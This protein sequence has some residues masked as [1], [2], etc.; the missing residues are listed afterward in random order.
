MCIALPEHC[1]PVCACKRS[2]DFCSVARVVLAYRT[3][4]RGTRLLLSSSLSARQIYCTYNICSSCRL[5]ALL[6]SNLKHAHARHHNT[7]QVV[8]AALTANTTTIAA[9]AG[10]WLVKYALAVGQI[11]AL[12]PNCAQSKHEAALSLVLFF[13]CILFRFFVGRRRL[14]SAL[15]LPP[16]AFGR[17]HAATTLQT[18]FWY[19]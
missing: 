17:R 7:T 2:A 1:S 9:G 13:I 8:C 15:A 12:A 4:G 6:A 16:I 14:H 19:V 11:Y 3:H 10:A 5:C 18:S